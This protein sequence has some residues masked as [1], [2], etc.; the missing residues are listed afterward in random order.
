MGYKLENNFRDLTPV[1]IAFL[2]YG[3][4]EYRRM[5]GNIKDMTKEEFAAMMGSRIVRK[6]P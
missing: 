6:R 5:V 3:H 2:V 4:P 1:Q